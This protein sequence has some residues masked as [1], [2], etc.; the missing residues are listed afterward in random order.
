MDDILAEE[1]LKSGVETMQQCVAMILVRLC[2]Y[3][4]SIEGEDQHKLLLKTMDVLMGQAT[5]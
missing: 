2:Q 4:V 5:R 1:V 3:D